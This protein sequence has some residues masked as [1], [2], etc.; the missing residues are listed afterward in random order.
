M[1]NEWGCLGELHSLLYQYAKRLAEK[2]KH[3][4]LR[5]PSASGCLLKTGSSRPSPWERLS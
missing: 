3:F 2:K 4:S 5:L 1:M